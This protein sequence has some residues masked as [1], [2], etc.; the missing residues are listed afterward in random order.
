MAAAR[1]F[2]L[3][4]C[5]V[6]ALIGTLTGVA[7]ATAADPTPPAG[8]GLAAPTVV[9]QGGAVTLAVK[10]TPGANPASTGISVTADLT[11]IGGPSSQQLFDDATQGDLVAA[12]NLFVVDA[13]VSAATAT[14]PKEIP[15]TITDAEGRLGAAVISFSVIEAVVVQKEPPDASAGGPYTVAEGGS[16]QLTAGGSTP[17]RDADSLTYAWDLDNDGVFETSGKSVRFSAGTLDG[18][19]TRT[20]TVRVSDGALSGTSQA[21]VDV[22]NVA[23]TAILSAP[24]SA[25]AGSTFT[26]ALTN[27]SDPSGADVAAGFTYAFDCGAGYTAFG[28]AASASCSATDTGTLS[29]GGKIRDKDGGV[30]EYRGQVSVVVTVASL[31]ELTKSLMTGAEIAAALCVKLDAAAAAAE[32]GNEASKQGE[33]GAYRNQVDA[34]I[35]KTV[36]AS[37]AEL[38]KRLSTRF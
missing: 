31:C 26:L 30:T 3:G 12:D 21:T 1:C 11:S 25:F 34:Q 27:P 36:S 17:T 6:V 10:V 28:S 24:A 15:V 9:L 16:T 5:A 20:V 32:R 18:P 22:A 33:L 38:L 29:V 7:R 4:A 13:S 19:S 37:A 23:P 8:F 14:G 2:R 35:G